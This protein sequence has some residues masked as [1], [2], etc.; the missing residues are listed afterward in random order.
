[1]ADPATIMA[2]VGMGMSAAGA[3]TGAI[4]AAKQGAAQQQMHAYQAGVARIN[5]QISKQNAAWT[6][7]AG[8]V[9]AQRAGMKGRTES[10]EI[11]ASQSGR[12]LDI[13][14]GSNRA[15]QESHQ[16]LVSHDLAMIRANAAHRAYGFDVQAMEHE[17]QA[18]VHGMAGSQA[19]TAGVLGVASSLI[20][21]A[22]SL[23]SKWMQYRS[24][25]GEGTDTDMTGS[26]EPAGP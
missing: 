22:S 11:V 19:K 10:G 20:G 23:A 1:M 3:V 24:M 21:G 5:E 25:F 6:R 8:E 2:G 14:S 12:G 18:T 26:L 7:A 16:E 13:T 15:V 9:S 4:G 17:A